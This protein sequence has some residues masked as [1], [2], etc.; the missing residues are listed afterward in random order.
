MWEEGGYVLRD[1]GGG[2]DGAEIRG[3]L[4]VGV[5]EA[6]CVDMWFACGEDDWDW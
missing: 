3:F 2:D 4:C 5:G 1:L 6:W